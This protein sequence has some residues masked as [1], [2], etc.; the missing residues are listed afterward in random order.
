[1]SSSSKRSATTKILHAFG[2]TDGRL[3]DDG[4]RLRLDRKINEGVQWI[5]DQE[6]VYPVGSHV[7]MYS[8]E[9]HDMTFLQQF[10]QGLE[11]T[12][13]LAEG[14]VTASRV[15]RDKQYLA[16]CTRVRTERT[17]NI[18]IFLLATRKLVATLPYVCD[19]DR[20]EVE[21]VDVNFS[22]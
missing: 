9:T 7:A 4:G 21:F 16:V 5:N 6:L 15:S 14:R 18:F 13:A 2:V 19:K 11:D 1:M 12:K 10:T 22:R 3:K 17:L 20:G 8:T